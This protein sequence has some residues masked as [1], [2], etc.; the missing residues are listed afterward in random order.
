MIFSHKKAQKSTRK[1]YFVPLC[2]LSLDC[3]SAL[4]R[5]LTRH[6]ALRGCQARNRHTIGRAAHV[7]ESDLIT[8]LDRR[9]IA[10]MFAAD[11]DFQVRS[12]GPALFK[13]HLHQTADALAVQ[14]LER[15]RLQDSFRQIIHNNLTRVVTRKTERRLGQIIRAE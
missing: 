12:G 9:W 1:V 3:S 10:T 13:S 2:G 15:V 5:R 4:S 14:F 7:V 8:K 11:S 6:H